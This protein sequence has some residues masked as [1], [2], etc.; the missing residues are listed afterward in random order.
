MLCF[1][2]LKLLYGRFIY[3][4]VNLVGLEGDA[5]WDVGMVDQQIEP[6]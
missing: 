3:G 1:R 4:A 5:H 6:S 2:A